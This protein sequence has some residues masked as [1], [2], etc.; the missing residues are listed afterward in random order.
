MQFTLDQTV[1]LVLMAAFLPVAG[2]I[3]VYNILHKKDNE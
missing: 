1:L 2:A 3:L